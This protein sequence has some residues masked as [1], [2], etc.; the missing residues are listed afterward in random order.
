MSPKKLLRAEVA[1]R[2]LGILGRVVAIVI[3]WGALVLQPLAVEAED[4]FK[5]AFQEIR[6]DVAEYPKDKGPQSFYVRLRSVAKWEAKS[7]AVCV[8]KS[9]SAWVRKWFHEDSASTAL[10]ARVRAPG[11]SQFESI[12]LFETTVSENPGTCTSH[13]VNRPIT[14]FYIVDPGQSFEVNVSMKWSEDSNVTGAASLVEAANDIL[15]L[16]GGSAKLISMVAADSVAK[17]AAKV[18]ESIAKHWK[19][20]NQ[21]DNDGQIS[22]YPPRSIAW[23]DHRDGLSFKAAQVVAEWSGVKVAKDRV[24][25]VD[26][27]PEYLDSYFSINGSYMNTARILAK[28]IGIEDEQSL[29][30]LLRVGLGGLNTVAARQISTAHAMR[31]FCTDLRQLLSS[32]LTENDELVS[33]Y[34]ILALETTYMD[35]AELRNDQCLSSNEVK[36]LAE[37]DPDFSVPQIDNRETRE[38]RDRAVQERMLPIT[39]ALRQQNRDAFNSLLSDPET[40]TLHVINSDVF[41]TREKGEWG[42][43]GEA[44]IEQL[45]SL[46]MRSGCYEAPSEQSLNAILMIALLPNSNS[47]G[48]LARFDESGKLKGLFFSAPDF[49]ADLTG[50][51]DWPAPSCPLQ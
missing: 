50:T 11:E 36:K 42:G 13:V 28:P 33:R 14:P 29:R 23:S 48:V 17:G 1:F 7:E 9:F 47:T 3:F 24:P 6:T 45:M 22:P 35:S 15:G 20:S 41:P 44:G 39:R 12:P 30:N 25:A 40:F 43:I 10:V 16:T 46:P 8:D 21:N 32:F 38:S 31:Q 51:K 49:V 37:L 5:R 26:I 34:A 2:H 19:Q 18:D 4:Q 27:I